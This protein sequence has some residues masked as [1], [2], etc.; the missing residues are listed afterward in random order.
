[1][2]HWT[3]WIVPSANDLVEWLNTIPQHIKS[4]IQLEY[5]LVKGLLQAIADIITDIEFLGLLLRKEYTCN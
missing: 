5:A 1:M 4:D 3:E 2:E